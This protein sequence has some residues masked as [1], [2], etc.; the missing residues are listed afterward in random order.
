MATPQHTPAGRGYDTT[1]I[2]FHHANDYYTFES[3]ECSAGGDSGEPSQRAVKDMWNME[4]NGPAENFPGKPATA[5]KNSPSCTVKHQHPKDGPC[6][7]EDDIF[8][9]RKRA[10]PVAMP[11]GL[12]QAAPLASRRQLPA[13]ATPSRIGGAVMEAPLTQRLAVPSR[14][15]YR[16]LIPIRCVGVHNIIKRHDKQTPLF[17]FWATHI[18]HGPLQVPDSQLARFNFINITSRQT[19]HAMVCIPPLPFDPCTIRCDR[20]VGKVAT[21]S[22]A[23][24]A[25]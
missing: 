1:L 24:K 13:P 15:P 11:L 22:R 20:A 5:K 12:R 14:S 3:G 2:Y 9:Q 18:V 21:V 7:Y 8:E 17:I 10:A 4:P 16:P 25:Q 23:R 19:Y 6:V